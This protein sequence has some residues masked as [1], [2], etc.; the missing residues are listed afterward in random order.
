[1]FIIRHAMNEDMPQ[2]LKLSKLVHSFNL[3]Q[4][5]DSLAAKID[6]SQRAF[7]GSVKD[8]KGREF[9]FVLEDLDSGSVIGTSAVYSKISW[10]GHP[11]LF[12]K[13]RKHE[14][15][16]H[17]LGTGQVHV[18]IQLDTDETGPSEIGGLILAPGYRGHPQKLGSLLSYAR[19]QFIGLHPKWFQ[20]RILAELMGALTPDSH[21]SLWDYLGRRFINLSY[22]EADTFNQRSKEFILKLFPSVEIYISLLPPEARQLVGKV[23]DETLPALH[24]LEKLGFKAQDHVDPFDGGPYLQASRDDI[25]IVRHSESRIL[26]GTSTSAT[27]SGVVSCVGEFGFR[28]MRSDFMVSGDSVRLPAKTIATLG[29]QSRASI[30]LTAFD[31]SSNALSLKRSPSLKGSPSLKSSPTRKAKRGSRSRG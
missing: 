10:P 1:M 2:L 20:Q 11:H 31:K 16:S 28:A 9:V 21:S 4:D 15:Y 14:H 25:P 12:F 30:G 5:K 27:H 23:G 26:A 18:T 6:R 3:P 24:M 19:F 8:P 7:A 13:V 22:T 17:D 29:A